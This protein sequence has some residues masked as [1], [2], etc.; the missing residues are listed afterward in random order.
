VGQQRDGAEFRFTAFEMS[1]IADRE[2]FWL[3]WLFGFLAGAKVAMHMQSETK[4]TDIYLSYSPDA[5]V[6]RGS[7]HN[8]Y[9][10]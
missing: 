6:K 4:S 3:F 1:E 9:V 8:N 2:C 7:Y 5:A 10:A